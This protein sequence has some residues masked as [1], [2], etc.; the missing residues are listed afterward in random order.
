VHTD[1]P[2]R[3]EIEA[4]LD[5]RETSVQRSS[6]VAPGTRLVAAMA[7]GLTIGFV[8]PCAR[9]TAASELNGRPVPLAPSLVRTSAAPKRSQTSAKTNGFETLM[10]ANSWSTSPA[11]WTRPFTPMTQMP[12]R[13]GRA[14]ASAG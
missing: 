5:T 1:I 3:S 4:L 11:P 12:N 13:S 10:M 6:V 9:S 14:R 8:T 7:P 2:T